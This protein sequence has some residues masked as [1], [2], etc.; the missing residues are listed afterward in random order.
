MS[1]LNAQPAVTPVRYPKKTL[2]LTG[3]TIKAMTLTAPGAFLWVMLQL[4]A[5]THGG[6]TD[7]WPGLV[8]ALLVALVTALSFAEL[9]RRYP[10]AGGRG[11]YYFVEKTLLDQ[12]RPAHPTLVRAAKFITGWAAHLFYW[13][14][15]GVLIS[16]ATLLLTYLLQQI[17]M[18]VLVPGQVLVAV[19]FALLVGLLAGRGITGSAS[20]AVVINLVQVI[21]LVLFSGLAIAFRWQNPLSATAWTYAS[22]VDIFIPH[23]VSGVLFQAALAMLILAGFEAST[24][25][26]AEALDPRRDV[27]RGTVL[28]LLGQGLAVYL[29]GYFAVNLAVSETLTVT[30]EHETFTGFNALIHSFAP[31]GALAQQ[32]GDRL[33]GGYGQTLA[34]ALALTVGLA[35][36]GAT[37]AAVNMGVRLSFAMAQD[38]DM[39]ELLGL[40]HD[41]FATPY[42]TV[43]IIVGVSA[44][45]GVLGALNLTTL[46][47]FVLAANIGVFLLY[48]LICG[49]T[50]VAFRGRADFNVVRHGVIPGV[51]LLGNL[52]LLAALIGVGLSSGNNTT[53][54]TVVALSVVGVWG[55]LSGAYLLWRKRR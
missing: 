7:M 44:V 2:G 26:A 3:V 20:L 39:P 14:Y 13:M 32:I 11:S 43:W 24:A 25:L 16:F 4:Q 28:S 6:Q 45:I 41:D 15:P 8:L 53:S 40:L 12:Q 36:L 18:E 23:S 50:F 9:A 52:G 5:S 38:R 33:V 30:V 51:G 19:V 22:P 47:G 31:L 46:T 1:L 29:F 37:L 48:A 10:E 54:A 34:L 42:V 17:G 27:P 35:L 21:G 49:L 55:V